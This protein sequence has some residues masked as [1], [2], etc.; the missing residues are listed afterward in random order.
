[1]V[2]IH[3]GGRNPKLNKALHRY[4]FRLTDQEN[5]RFLSLFE[6]SGLDTK[7][8][9]IVALLFERQIKSIKIDAGAMEYCTKLSRLFA[10]F[11][12]IGVN[13]N[14]IVK[15]LH[16]TFG[17]KKTVFYIGKLEKQTLEL[18][19]LCKDILILSKQFESEYLLNK[20]KL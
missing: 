16:T 13:Y 2:Q 14:Q 6:D 11:R 20:E 8:K 1:M 10:Q 19:D 17:D 5:A 7:A 4:V 12:A 3:K 9:F 15:I 18:A